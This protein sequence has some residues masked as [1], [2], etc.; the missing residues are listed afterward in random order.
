MASVIPAT[1]GS[2]QQTCPAR[3]APSLKC[4]G[5]AG[6]GVRN[7]SN[8]GQHAAKATKREHNKHINVQCSRG[9]A[10][11]KDLHWS[12]NAQSTVQ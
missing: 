6:N 8:P 1:P 11:N 7:P 5:Q 2:R 3:G 9:T 12:K 4:G 10:K